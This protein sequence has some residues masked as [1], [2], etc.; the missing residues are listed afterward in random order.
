MEYR[1]EA[2]V[3][4]VSDPDRSKA[5]YEQCGFHLDVDHQAGD[6]FR[7]IQF[8]PPGSACSVTF[9]VG[10]GSRDPGSAE[11]LH[12]VVTDIAAAHADLTGRGVH[13]EP[14]RHMTPEGWQDGPDPQHQNYNSFAAF[15][16]PDGN[17]WLLQE[18]G[19]PDA[20]GT[21]G[22]TA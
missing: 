8:T 4:S 16:D 21:P 18:V 2:I 3:L 11:G 14:I 12:L 5:F 20:A 6:E 17:G 15:A 7:V 9:G 13:V 19:H 1:L 22:P 10:I